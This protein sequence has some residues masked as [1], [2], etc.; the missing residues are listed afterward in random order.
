M[1]SIFVLK[2]G[3]Q[4][5]EILEYVMKNSH[6]NASNDTTECGMV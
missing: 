4:K 3:I 6:I 2:C 5:T 1:R